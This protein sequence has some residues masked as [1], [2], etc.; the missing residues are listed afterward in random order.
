MIYSFFIGFFGA[1]IV[2]YVLNNT[3]TY[4]EDITHRRMADVRGK[5]TRY[6]IKRSGIYTTLYRCPNPNRGPSWNTIDHVKNCL[7]TYHSF[8][9]NDFNGYNWFMHIENYKEL[10]EDLQELLLEEYFKDDK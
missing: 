3:Y 9:D 6:V 2:F 7:N 10:C 1:A 5:R 8:K 4:I